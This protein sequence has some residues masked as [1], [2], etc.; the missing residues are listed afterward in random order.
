MTENMQAAIDLPEAVYLASLPHR[1]DFY[2]R[3]GW[4]QLSNRHSATE[5]TAF[6]DDEFTRTERS[7]ALD[8]ARRYTQEP[9]LRRSRTIKWISIYDSGY[10]PLLRTI[11]DPP[12]ILFYRGS[13]NFGAHGQNYVGIVGTRK[14][15]PLVPYVV[16][17]YVRSI[18]MHKPCIV[19]GFA[20]GVDR[21]AHLAAMH[22]HLEGVAVLGAGLWHAGPRSNLDLVNRA[23]HFPG[24]LTLVSEF[25]PHVPGY[26]GNF[27]RRNRI[28]AGMCPRLALLQAPHGSG[29]LITGQFALDEGREVQVFDHPAFDE[30]PGSNAGNRSLLADGATPIVLDG[31]NQTLQ[32]SPDIYG[33]QLRFWNPAG[34]RTDFALR[35]C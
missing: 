3:G 19:S 17:E 22:F 11:F 7:V 12:A 24:A 32:S 16:R 20:R 15:H 26:P 30:E 35:Q 2:R 8:S 27:P 28:I 34:S 5:R 18:A 4:S 31:L 25:A 33:R 23:E 14:I 13:A 6:I 9:F 29:A 21:L 10:P 1:S